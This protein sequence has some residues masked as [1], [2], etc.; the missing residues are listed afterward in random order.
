MI[1]SYDLN[2]MSMTQVQSYILPCHWPPHRSPVVGATTTYQDF[3]V[4]LMNESLI[5][6]SYDF[7]NFYLVQG[8][9]GTLSRI[10]IQLF[11][12]VYELAHGEDSPRHHPTSSPPLFQLLHKEILGQAPMFHP[13]VHLQ[14]RFPS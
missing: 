9:L 7:H 6:Y 11:T 2:I 14:L 3:H 12:T 1:G 5:N 13:T 8:L 10:T 4:L